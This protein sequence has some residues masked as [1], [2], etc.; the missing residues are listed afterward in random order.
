M[1]ERLIYMIMGKIEN[2][3]SN[4]FKAFSWVDSPLKKPKIVDRNKSVH[5]PRKKT[6]H[7]QTRFLS[8]GSKMCIRVTWCKWVKRNIIC[9]C[10]SCLLILTFTEN[11]FTRIYTKRQKQIKTDHSKLLDCLIRNKIMPAWE[12]SEEYYYQLI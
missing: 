2:I 4:H 8:V 1:Q 12:I 9:K 10:V 6:T 3:I 11:I 7:T 5:L